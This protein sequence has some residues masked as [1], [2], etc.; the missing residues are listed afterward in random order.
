MEAANWIIDREE[1]PLSPERQAAFDAWLAASDLNKAAYWRME[2]RW[3]EADRMA[4]L[5]APREAEADP[6]RIRWWIPTAIAASLA[7]AVGSQF[8]PVFKRGDA[9]VQ[10][11]TTTYATDLGK[12]RMVGFADGSRVQ[13]NTASSVRTAMTSTK[14]EIWLDKGEAFFSVAHVD[15]QPFV[16]HAGDRQITVL[17]TKFSVRRDGAKVTVVVLEGKV[18]VDQ[19]EDNRLVRSSII[20]GGDI[21][22]GV[23]PSTMVTARSPARVEGALSWRD[24]MLTFDQEQL[25]MIAAEFN[26]YNARKMV[27]KDGDAGALRIGGVFRANDPDGFVELLRDAY[28]LKIEEAGSEIRISD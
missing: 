20:V 2:L 19:L 8:L 17:G 10:V 9:P 7:L 24:G 1:G 27:V 12:R 18:R 5:G 4:S 3:E 28:G 11:A 16:V 6:H 25:V 23:G 26:R 13:L 22:L 21:A 15:G 14:R